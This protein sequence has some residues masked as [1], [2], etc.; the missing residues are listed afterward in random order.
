MATQTQTPP[1]RRRKVECGPL[2]LK[3]PNAPPLLERLKST[4]A[5]R[6][7]AIQSSRQN[8]A[9]RLY[10]KNA[11]LRP[12]C[13]PYGR[14]FVSIWKPL[15]LVTIISCITT[16]LIV[17]N[18]NDDEIISFCQ[19]KTSSES[20]LSYIIISLTFLLVFRLNRAAVRH[21]EAR[22]LCGLM[23]V[24]LRDTIV[25]SNASL[26][27]DNPDSRDALCA[28]A[29][30]YPVCFAWYM[31]TIADSQIFDE[32]RFRSML[33]GL[34]DEDT[35]STLIA[36]K[37]RPMALIQMALSEL[38]SS[39]E[40]LPDTPIQAE[41]Y[42]QLAKMIRGLGLSLGGCERIQ[43]TPLPYVYVVH[44]RSFLVIVL[45][46]MPILFACDWEWATIPLSVLIAFGLLGIEAASV[47]CEQPF[48]PRPSK[49]HHDVEK[50]CV[51]VST[52][53][54]DLLRMNDSILEQNNRSDLEDGMRLQK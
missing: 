42:G 20:A 2:S 26:S 39:F 3:Q 40:G 34:F 35:V 47:E 49:N 4:S 11:W 52:E 1:L 48:S 51:V 53:A 8:N 18:K 25:Q 33:D 38:E 30:G 22:Q 43:G 41:A 7:N 6:H 45:A 12:M 23:I 32:A 9:I 29:V 46:A 21:Y 44:L 37:N 16:P 19:E 14:N 54:Q 36:A 27:H 17:L 50:F 28:F 13:S 31:W 15:F 10:N 24:N 5:S